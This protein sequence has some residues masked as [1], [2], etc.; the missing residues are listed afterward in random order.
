MNSGGGQP[1]V[2]VVVGV[3]VIV[4][5]V[6]VVVVSVSCPSSKLELMYTPVATTA[7]RKTASTAMSARFR[8]GIFLRTSFFQW[9][10]SYLSL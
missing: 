6:V 9:E 8:S 1:V 5:V 10:L 2:Q 4:V 7:S 3:V